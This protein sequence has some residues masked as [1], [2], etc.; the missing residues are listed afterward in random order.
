MKSPFPGMDP[1]LEQHWGD[2]HASCVIYTRDLLQQQL[3]TD[4]RA[5]VEERVFVEASY[6]VRRGIIPDVRV[7]EVK[8]RRNRGSGGGA[9]VLVG[10]EPLV[11]EITDE[12]A[13][14]GHIEIF[15]VNNRHKVVTTIEFLSL[16]NK[17]PGPGKKLFDRKRD[18]LRAARVSLVEIDLL[19]SGKRN[20]SIPKNRIPLTHRTTYQIC[21]RRGWEDFKIEVYRAPLQSP[22]PKIKIPLRQSDADVALDLQSVIDQCYQKGRYDDIDYTE[23]PF[24]PLKP[25]DEK[26]IHELLKSKGLR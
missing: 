24:T 26:W 7:E 9:A 25:S 1:Y 8:G 5:R 12:P 4:L 18:E 11:L 23:D 17:L 10:D 22:L 15:D 2:V 14:Q 6:D 20:L 19:R 21:V 3:P 16:S 13:T